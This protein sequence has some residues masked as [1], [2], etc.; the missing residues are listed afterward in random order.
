MCTTDCLHMLS[1][2]KKTGKESWQLMLP[3]DLAVAG[4]TFRSFPVNRLCFHFKNPLPRKL[5]HC[6]FF[7]ITIGPEEY[8]QWLLALQPKQATL[9]D[10]SRQKAKGVVRYCALYKS[11]ILSAA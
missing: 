2:G 5:L 4:I 1:E 7:S 10:D 3:R 9:G 11:K 6:S 8:S